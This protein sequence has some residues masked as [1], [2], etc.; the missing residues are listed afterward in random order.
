MTK[1]K[2]FNSLHELMDTY[3]KKKGSLGNEAMQLGD[4]EGTQGNWGSPSAA[5]M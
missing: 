2:E 5:A 3:R 1:K 4:Q